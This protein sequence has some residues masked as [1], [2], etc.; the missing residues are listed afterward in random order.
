MMLYL[1]SDIKLPLITWDDCAV[2]SLC[3]TELP[4]GCESVKAQFSKPFVYYI[5]AYEG[6]G[7]GFS[8][9]IYEIT[10]EDDRLA[11]EQGRTSVIELINYITTNIKHTDKFELF[12]CLA[13]N[14]AICPEVHDKIFLSNFS[15][16][17]YFEFQ[18]KQ[19]IEINK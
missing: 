16:D 11:F 3:V 19:Y 12:S 6:C 9:G 4:A 7:C 10:D 5:G 14:E 2:Q 18:D 17:D 13:G 1:A 8:F 15:I